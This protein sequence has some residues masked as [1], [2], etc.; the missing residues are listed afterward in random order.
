[1]RR[2]YANFTYQ[3]ASWIKPRRIVAEVERHPGALCPR[4]G[5]IVTNMARPAENGVAFYN[6]R[7]LPPSQMIDVVIAGNDGKILEARGRV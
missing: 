6:K 5:F 2:S 3:A 4:V 7:N 1:M